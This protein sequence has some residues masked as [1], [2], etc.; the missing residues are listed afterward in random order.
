M[1][2]LCREGDMLCRLAGD[3]FV[4]LATSA[5]DNI[6]LLADRLVSGIAEPFVLTGEDRAQ[7]SASIGITL[8]GP[9]DILVNAIERADQAMY[10]A[11]NSGKNRH[12]LWNPQQHV[13]S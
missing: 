6:E 10:R 7:V 5:N 11:K 8:V 1:Q 2:Q 12:C 9:K 3:E 13:G 4:I